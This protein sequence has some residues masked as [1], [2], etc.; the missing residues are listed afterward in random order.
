MSFKDLVYTKII[1][2]IDGFVIQFL[3]AVA[4]LFFIYGIFKFFFTGGEENR[5]KGK[6]FAV[7]GLVGLVVLFSVWSLV[8]ILLTSFNLGGN[9]APPGSAAHQVPRGGICE[10]G[11]DCRSGVCTLRGI[12]T[13]TCE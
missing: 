12:R 6:Q 9:T 5:Q 7:W 4:F 11:L 2:F 3:Y 10:S 8:G 1:P 13:S